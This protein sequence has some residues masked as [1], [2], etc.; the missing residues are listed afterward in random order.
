MLLKPRSQDRGPVLNRQHADE[1]WQLEDNCFDQGSSETWRMKYCTLGVV[2]ETIVRG[3]HARY[4]NVVC[5]RVRAASLVWAAAHG[6][7]R[8]LWNTWK[9]LNSHIGVEAELNRGNV[10]L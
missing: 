7:D 1:K 5:L 3:R 9:S 6:E 10:L 4:I 2:F 8:I